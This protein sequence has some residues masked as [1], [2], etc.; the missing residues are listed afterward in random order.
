M[1]NAVFFFFTLLFASCS[2]IIDSIT[3]EIVE[4]IPKDVKIIFTT[5][6]PDSDEINVSY[7][8]FEIDEWVYGP[9]EFYYDSN[10]NSEPII[11]SFPEYPY[12]EI[13][14]DAYRKNG[15]AYLLK[16]QILINDVL[17]LDNETVGSEEVWAQ[18][19]FNYDIVD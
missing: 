10:G 5:S 4:I 15:H 12:N 9:R 11:I 16:V 13:A 17:V 18:V 6:A 2:T 8:D 1:K 14:G 7:K 3:P 19:F